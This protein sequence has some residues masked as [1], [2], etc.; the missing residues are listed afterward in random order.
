M[1]TDLSLSKTFMDFTV[2]GQVR[3]WS[4]ML[5]DSGNFF[6]VKNDEVELVLWS[7]KSGSRG[8]VPETIISQIVLDSVLSL[9][10]I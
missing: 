3:N 7:I 10:I 6:G 4:I 9:F 1:T 5:M 8:K 2:G